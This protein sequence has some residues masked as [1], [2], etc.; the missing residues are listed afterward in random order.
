[1]EDVLKDIGQELRGY[2]A[3]C[4]KRSLGPDLTEPVKKGW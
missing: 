2:V 3:E 1:V 4:S